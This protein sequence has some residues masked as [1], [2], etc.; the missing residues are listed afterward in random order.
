MA[1]P[2]QVDVYVAPP[3]PT[4]TGST[5]PAKTVWSPISITLIQGPM[6]AAVVD[7]PI[8]IDQTTALADWIKKTAPGKKLT[9][10]YI[11]HAHGDHLFG[12]PVLQKRFPGLKIVATAKVAEGVQTQYA[13]ALYDNLWA[14]YFPNGQ[15]PAEKPPAEPLPD[16]GEFEV[17]GHTL[18]GIDVEHSDCDASSILHVPSLKLVVGGDVV[19]GDCYQHL[20]QANTA[21]KRRSWLNALDLVDS[22]RPNI[23][24]PGHKRASQVDGA[25]LVEATRKYILDFERELEAASG[26]EELEKRMKELY[27][28]RWNEYILEW[29]CKAS[30]AARGQ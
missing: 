11:T 3:I 12:A 8:T 4:V 20:G 15:L 24:V 18:K 22:L 10:L 13:P 1:S 16:S 6:S 30:F 17:D 2:L 7:T 5:D 9:H 21:E 19:Y 27:P 25:Y 29:G 26:P 23:V 14:K 28:Q